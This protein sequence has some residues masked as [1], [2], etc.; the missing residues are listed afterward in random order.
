[1]KLQN[2]LQT[3]D[4][5][6]LQYVLK[7]ISAQ[8]LQIVIDAIA[9]QPEIAAEIQ[10]LKNLYADISVVE[11]NPAD[12]SLSIERRKKLFENTI[13]KKSESSR[14][15]SWLASFGKFRY[16]TGGLVAATFAILVF[17]QSLKHEVKNSKQLS[18]TVSVSE[19]LLEAPQAPPTQPA[20]GMPTMNEARGRGGG[21][22]QSESPVEAAKEAKQLEPQPET[23]ADSSGGAPIVTAASSDKAEMEQAPPMEQ[24]V[25]LYAAAADSV[26]EKSLEKKATEGRVV[27]SPSVPNMKPTSASGSESSGLLGGAKTFAASNI[28]TKSGASANSKDST[29]LSAFGSGGVSIKG[30]TSTVESKVKV[31]EN[32][33]TVQVSAEKLSLD[34]QI[35]LRLEIMKCL[36]QNRIGRAVDM[37]YDIK[38]SKLTHSLQNLH[39]VEQIIVSCISGKL[40]EAKLNTVNDLKSVLIKI[41][42][43]PMSNN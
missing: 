3:D 1:M 39:A 18:D 40:S 9:Q 12:L 25:E 13:Y 32:N 26:D 7:E 35:H 10:E 2:K 36:S 16:A 30:A 37:N 27:E 29:L 38:T 8:D 4:P 5:R 31:Q 15:W 19:L 21:L 28:A 33:Y 14:W 23:I 24:N 43:E 11:S 34:L 42:I 41:D 20:A 22:A 17:N 6:L